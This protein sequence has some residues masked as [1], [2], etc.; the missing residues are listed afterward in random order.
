VA[1]VELLDAALQA[2]ARG[3]FTT[4]AGGVSGPPWD[5]LNL[6]LH[7]DDEAR[8]V[9]TNRD[10]LVRAAG[11]RELAF[12]QQVH[13]S[14]VAVVE[15]ASSRGSTAGVRGVDALVTRTRGLGLVVM[16]ADCLPVLLADPEGGVVG[17][18]HAGRAGLLAGVLQRAV[19][20]M[21]GLGA[22]PARTRAVVGPA[23]GACCY[24]VPADMAD[25]AEHQ[26]PG[27]RATTRR[28]TP[29]LDLRAGAVRALGLAG[30]D[31]VQHI[32]ACTLDDPRFYSYRRDGRTG[33]HAGVAWLTP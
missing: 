14:G 6:A 20:A 16:A 31:E 18:A 26:L 23:A 4:R 21:A 27:V 9:L 22:D 32:D 8:R 33:R 7:V 29:S 25:D 2:P 11:V 5:A 28:G 13:G 12:A 10:L 1:G 15:R 3:V 24:E 19:E 17:A 30:V